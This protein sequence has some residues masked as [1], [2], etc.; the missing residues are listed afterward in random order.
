MSLVSTMGVKE[1]A[2]FLDLTPSYVRDMAR[3]GKIPPDCIIRP[4]GC[5][6]YRFDRKKIEE[7]A[8]AQA[9]P[10]KNACDSESE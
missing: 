6:K 10:L 1:L 7:W 3:Y 8:R 2:E 9:S 4:Q 5:R